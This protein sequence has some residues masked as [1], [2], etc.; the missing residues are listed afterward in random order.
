MKVREGEYFH[1]D[2][3]NVVQKMLLKCDTFE[4]IDLLINIDR[5]PIAK[6]S[7]ASLWPILCS[8]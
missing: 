6:S 7:N 5:L 4:S 2:L 1:W 3:D 8:K